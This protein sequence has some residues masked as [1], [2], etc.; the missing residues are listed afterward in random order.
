MTVKP[1]IQLSESKKVESK[2]GGST[3]QATISIFDDKLV[4]DYIIV[5][6]STGSLNSDQK[7]N[8]EV[9]YGFN[10]S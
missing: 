4:V 3:S 1:R 9:I 10:A 7:L 6:D 5:M 2:I 8:Q